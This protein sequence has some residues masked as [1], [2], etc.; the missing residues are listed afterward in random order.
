MVPIS[1][2]KKGIVKN[3]LSAG[4]MLAIVL[5]DVS[6]RPRE[7]PG[8]RVVAPTSFPYMDILLSFVVGTTNYSSPK[9]T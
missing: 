1:A 8:R 4:A 3:T 6:K 9:T 5:A 7:F 2:T